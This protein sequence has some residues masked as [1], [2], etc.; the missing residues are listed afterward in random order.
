[1]AIA[2]VGQKL[3][4]TRL[5]SDDGS[6]SAVSVIKIEPNRVVQKKTADTDGYNAVQITTGVKNNRKGQAKVGRISSALKGHYAKASQEI[7]L[8][9][10]EIRASETE[11]AEMSAFDVS[12]FGA[13][14]FVNVTGQSKGKG[15]QGGVKRHNFSMQDATH[16]NSLSHRALGST[17]QCQTPGRVFKGKKMAG[18]MGNEQVTQECLEVLRVDSERNLLLIKGAIPG[19]KNGFVK[20]I[21]SDKKNSVNAQISKQLAEENAA[22]AQEIEA[23]EAATEEAPVVVEAPIDAAAEEAPVETKI[24]AAEAVETESDETENETDEKEET[25]DK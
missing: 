19:A 22:K 18:Q 21:L 3:G 16:G 1:M 24:E 14:H 25:E 17:G 23:A 5:L 20:V 8:G 7:G 13:G 10:W 11:L 6:A 2:L 12:F 15:F 4:M 9:L